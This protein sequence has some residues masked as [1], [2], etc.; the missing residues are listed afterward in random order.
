MDQAS[1]SNIWNVNTPQVQVGHE[2]HEFTIKNRKNDGCAKEFI[3][4]VLDSVLRLKNEMKPLHSAAV[5]EQI[6]CL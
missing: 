5:I 4:A 6:Y 1:R 2:T 3:I